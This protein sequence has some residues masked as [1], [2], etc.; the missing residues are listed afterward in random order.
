MHLD[1]PTLFLVSTCVTGLL[2]IFFLPEVYD[3]VYSHSLIAPEPPTLVLAAFAVLLI[4]SKR[5]HF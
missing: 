1:L 3:W 5:A 4:R 2:G